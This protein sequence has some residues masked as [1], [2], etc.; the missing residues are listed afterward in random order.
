MS[1]LLVIKILPTVPEALEFIGVEVVM[2]DGS[3]IQLSPAGAVIGSFRF[4]FYAPIVLGEMDYV[5][6][7][8]GVVLPVN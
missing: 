2:K 8:D 5:R 6:I 1:F 7:P 3:V 4:K